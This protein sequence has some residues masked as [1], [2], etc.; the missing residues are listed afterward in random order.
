VG[1]VSQRAD[2][3]RARRGADALCLQ[4]AL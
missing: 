1:A 2:G 3:L 4:R